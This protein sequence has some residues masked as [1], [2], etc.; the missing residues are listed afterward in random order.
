M[1]E[2]KV[3]ELPAE[4]DHARVK[5]VITATRA[6]LTSTRNVMKGKVRFG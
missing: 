4:K 6:A 2:L 5:A 3:P 1:R